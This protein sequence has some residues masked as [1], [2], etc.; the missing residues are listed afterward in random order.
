MAFVGLRLLL[1]AHAALC[2]LSTGHS[3]LARPYG[4]RREALLSPHSIYFPCQQDGKGEVEDEVGKPAPSE[5]GG[6]EP[7]GKIGVGKE[8]GREQLSGRRAIIGAHRTMAT[9]CSCGSRTL[10]RHEAWCQ[11]IW[12]CFHYGYP[13]EAESL[14][15]ST[16]LLYHLPRHDSE[17]G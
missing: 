14:I 10:S 15:P 1:G 17:I 12:G 6:V 13:Q 7:A 16:A 9:Q 4:N 11:V 3:F 5:A 8:N 2:V